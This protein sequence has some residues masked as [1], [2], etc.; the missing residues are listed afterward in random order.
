M[1]SHDIAKTG[2]EL[3]DAD[4]QALEPA[5]PFKAWNPFFS[6][7]YSVTEWSSE[8]GRTQVRS[9]RTTFSNGKLRTERFQGEAEGGVYDSMVEQMQRQAATQ[10]ELM[11]KAFTWFL[12]QA[13]RER[14]KSD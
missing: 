13:V 4:E 3:I 6:F 10:V 8:G 1:S 2:T 9:Q 7:H 12:P 5:S 14:L 11:M